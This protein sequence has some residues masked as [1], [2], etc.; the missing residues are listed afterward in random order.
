MLLL[1][2]NFLLA[3]ELAGVTFPDTFSLEEHDLSLRGIGLREKYWIDIYVAALYLPQSFIAKQPTATEIILADVPKS[4]QTE[5]IFPNV[6]KEKMIETLQENINNNPKI[7][8]ST[9]L[10]MKQCE[11][12]MEDYEDGDQVSFDYVPGIGTSIIVKGTK[13]GT[14]EGLDFMKALFSIFIGKNPASQ[15]LKSG[16]LS[17]KK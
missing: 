4:I 3:A 2:S 7:S 5:F 16:L 13:K 9:R 1:L 6:P 12:W 11:M 10:K 8:D 17:S 15:Q 14:I